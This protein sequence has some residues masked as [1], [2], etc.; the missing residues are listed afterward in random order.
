MEVIKFET[1]LKNK[2]HEVCFDP[3]VN[4]VYPA[5]FESHYRNFREN[6]YYTEKKGVDGFPKHPGEAIDFI[7][8]RNSRLKLEL[9]QK[10]NLRCKY[11]FYNPEV[12]PTRKHTNKAMSPEI[13]S[14]SIDFYQRLKSTPTARNQ[15][16]I[17]FYG[18]EPTLEPGLI[19]QAVTEAKQKMDDCHVGYYLTTNG[20]FHR[21][22]QLIDFIV[23]HN[24]TIQ[25]SLDGVQEEH[26]KFRVDLKGDGCYEDVI[27]SLRKLK[28][29]PRVKIL[30]TMHPQHDWRKLDKLF[31]IL[32]DL[33]PEWQVS[34]SS[35]EVTAISNQDKK[36]KL[37]KELQDKLRDFREGIADK[38]ERNIA[39]S[40]VED[41][42]LRA[43]FTDY[44]FKFTNH[45]KKTR[46][47][48]T[49]FPGAEILF[50]DVDGKFH[51]CEKIPTSMEIGDIEHG[52]DAEA[53]F[54]LWN[55]LHQLSRDLECH[56]CP[57]QN[58][59]NL[60]F[61]KLQGGCGGMGSF[62]CGEDRKRTMQDLLEFIC[63]IKMLGGVQG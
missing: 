46:F 7:A 58:M 13:V 19:Y 27:K 14:Q 17:S 61:V 21:N 52:I 43:V 42:Y 44:S 25:F 54:K 49:C 47:A 10:C 4:Q 55:H 20:T 15:F 18:G 30:V 1:K 33:N 36:E 48:K 62:E 60:C 31:K 9:T 37:K 12:Y 38:L 59:C 53:I 51:M 11:C 34:L 28:H 35:V 45:W 16:S 24:F 63:R 39:L 32:R 57:Y 5:R 3:F 29:Y 6:P 8:R 23:K 50:V 26:D 2:I 56:D 22:D 41:K 40:P